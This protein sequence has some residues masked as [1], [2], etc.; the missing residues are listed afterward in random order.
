MNNYEIKLIGVHQELQN[1][2]PKSAVFLYHPQIDHV[3]LLG[4]LYYKVHEVIHFGNDFERLPMLLVK[5]IE[6]QP[7][8]I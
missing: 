1:H 5:F 2:I 3:V 4:Q 7:N 6:N 8:F